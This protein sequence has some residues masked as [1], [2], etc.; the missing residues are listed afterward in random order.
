MAYPTSGRDLD[1]STINKW[2]VRKDGPVDCMYKDDAV[3]DTLREAGK[4]QV[5]KGRPQ[6]K[7][8]FRTLDG[9]EFL[10]DAPMLNKSAGPTNITGDEVIAGVGHDPLEK[11]LWPLSMKVDI[12]LF[13]EFDKIRNAGTQAMVDEE[14]ARI[15][16]KTLAMLAAVDYDICARD[17]LTGVSTYK[18]VNGLPALID[19]AGQSDTK[20]VAGITRSS[21]V[22]GWCNRKT[23]TAGA[24]TTYYSKLTVQQAL[25]NASSK[26][27]R[28][29]MLLTDPTTYAAIL[30][31]FLS[32]GQVQLQKDTDPDT[33]YQS[34]G[35]L[36]CKVVTDDDI[37]DGFIYG[38]PTEDMWFAVNKHHQFHVGDRHEAP[39]QF[40]DYRKLSFAGQLG[41]RRF[42]GAGV[43]SG[44][45]A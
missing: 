43:S 26:A 42:S 2:L 31:H 21:S 18:G 12:V 14:Q 17:S 16:E 37:A 9:G 36:G 13:T 5:K 19:I 33:G 29:N 40:L 41:F 27:A 7:S 6:L 4:R 3:L 8:S 34:F 28:W 45:T 32:L 38:L 24:F 44:W 1:T 22:L 10:Q 20:A 30:N 23:T 39:N 25:C 11:A 35:W 15:T